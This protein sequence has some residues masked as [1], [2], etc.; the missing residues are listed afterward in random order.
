MISVE[1]E[2]LENFIPQEYYERNDRTYFKW[3]KRNSYVE[4]RIPAFKIGKEYSKTCQII[5]N[6]GRN[7]N[8][9]VTR[10]DEYSL[11]VLR[12]M[13]NRLDKNQ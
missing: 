6:I 9:R 10:T 5:S 1:E 3:H 4:V 11:S 7:N 12:T 13:L 8:S 2:I